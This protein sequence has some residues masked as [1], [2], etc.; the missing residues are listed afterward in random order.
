MVHEIERRRRWLPFQTLLMADNRLPDQDLPSTT[1]SEAAADRAVAERRAVLRRVAIG[2][3]VVVATVHGRT[4]WAQGQG[5][6]GAGC[7]PLPSDQ[8]TTNDTTTAPVL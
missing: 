4:V 6:G 8:C 5:S 7:S 2:L 1:A 3:P